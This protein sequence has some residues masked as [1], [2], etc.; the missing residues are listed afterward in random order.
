MYPSQDTPGYGVF[1]KNVC[2]GI[3][4]YGIKTKYLSVISGR[5]NRLIDKIRK[6]V[7]FYWSIFWNYF[8][9]YDCIY[10][11]FPTFSAPMLYLLMHVKKKK[12]VINFHGEDLLYQNE[13]RLQHALGRINDKLTK[14]FA[15]KIV[16]PSSYFKKI[17]VDRNLA[18]IENVF[19]SPSGGID[20]NIFNCVRSE[21]KNGCIHIGFVGRLE[22]LKGVKEFLE[23]YKILKSMQEVK[24]TIIGYGPLNDVVKEEAEQDKKLEVIYGIPQ[25]ELPKYYRSF[26]LFIFPSKRRSESLGLVGI[27]AMACGTPIIGSEIGGIASYVKHKKNGYLARLD[28]LVNDIVEY[29]MDYGRLSAEERTHMIMDCINTASNYHR[30]KVCEELGVFF[31]KLDG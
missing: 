28:N 9:S 31:Q 18:P 20:E 29:T 21:S 11:H 13:S 12:L 14:K 1:V 16:V 4:Q 2:D 8:A 7:I 19:V 6:Y 23:A 27:E 17:V 30:T 3:A 22:E 10:C 24:A 25:T 26:D 15:T 5:G